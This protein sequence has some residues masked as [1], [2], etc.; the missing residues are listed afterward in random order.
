MRKEKRAYNPKR[1]QW[2]RR[3]TGSEGRGQGQGKRKSDKEGDGNVLRR[4]GI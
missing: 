2:E 4:K 3:A 1:R